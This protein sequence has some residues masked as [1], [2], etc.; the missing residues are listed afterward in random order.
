ATRPASRRRTISTRGRS[1]SSSGCRRRNAPRRISTRSSPTRGG[2]WSIATPGSNRSPA[3]IADPPSARGAPSPPTA[4]D[5]VEDLAQPLR[6]TQVAQARAARGEPEQARDVAVAQLLEVPH[7]E[8]LAVL[9]L[10][11]FERGAQLLDRLLVER[12]RLRRP[13]SA[14]GDRARD[15]DAARVRDAA[16]ERDLAP[17]VA[18]L[19]AEVVA[20]ELDQLLAGDE[21]QPEMERH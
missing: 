19:G 18:H 14:V 12:G 1:R 11:R 9:A 20:V 7:H 17:R 2:A 21:A 10:H 15:R 13:R 5:L 8:H 6:R 4:A 16:E 3:R